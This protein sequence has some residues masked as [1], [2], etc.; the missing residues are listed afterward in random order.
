ML[1]RLSSR[2]TRLEPAARLS[3]GLVW[4]AGTICINRA[5]WQLLYYSTSGSCWCTIQSM[6]AAAYST[7]G[8]CCTIQP[9]PAAAVLFN[10]WQLLYYLTNGSCCTIQSIVA[11]VL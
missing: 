9:M 5:K 3:A 4:C 6:A 8:S 11:A 10:Q 2:E 1:A 7:N